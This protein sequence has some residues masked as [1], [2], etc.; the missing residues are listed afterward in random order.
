MN[1]PNRLSILR[2]ILIPFMLVA[3]YVDAIP[4]RY[5]ITAVIF[6]V[7][8]FTDFLDGYIARKYNLVT[9]FGK[10]IDPIADKI[11]V[12]SAFVIMLTD[13]IVLSGVI[14]EKFGAVIGGVGVTVIVAREMT[15]SVLRMIAAEKGIVLAAEKIGK[16][17]TF[18]TDL[19]IALLLI[20]AQFYASASTV[21]TVM[22]VISL[23]FYC[24]AVALTIYSGVFYLVKNKD[25]FKQCK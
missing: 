17:K 25:L 18:V 4:C 10:F 16:V 6:L 15:V 20:T 5:V 12:L 3:F 21:Y 2:I 8:A 11:L 19:A 1:L 14:G 9:D 22:Y 13:P 24:V 7:A 23:A